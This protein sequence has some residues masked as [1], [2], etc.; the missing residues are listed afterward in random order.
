MVTASNEIC[1][2]HRFTQCLF[3]CIVVVFMRIE[4]KWEG[5][6]EGEPSIYLYVKFFFDMSNMPEKTC[7]IFFLNN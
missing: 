3:Y 7:Q 4:L 5:V 6:V 1:E 2:H